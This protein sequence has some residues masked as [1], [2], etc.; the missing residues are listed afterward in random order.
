MPETIEHCF[1]VCKD[2]ILFWDVIHRNLQKYFDLNSHSIRYLVAP[3][4]DVPFD[5]FLLIGLH[6]LWKSRMQD[7][8]A[9][10]TISSRSHFVQMII[11]LKDIYDQEECQPAWYPLLIRCLT[12]PYKFLL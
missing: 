10:K 5:M 9:E 11:H 12:S 4:E 3:Y 7:R 8:N 1:I 6:S 2:A